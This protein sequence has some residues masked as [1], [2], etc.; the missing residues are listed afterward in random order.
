MT[1]AKVVTKFTA[2][3]PLKDTFGAVRSPE[4]EKF[5]AVARV[6]AVVALPVKAPVKP[7]EVI[8]VAPVTIPAS[9]IIVPSRTIVD[10]DTGVILRLPEVEDKTLP[11]RF[12]LS[13][14]NAVRVPREVTLA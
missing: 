6:V 2:P 7:V 13:T 4:A 9:T 3:P 11:L 12:K 5:L 10:P 8:E 1:V 14:C